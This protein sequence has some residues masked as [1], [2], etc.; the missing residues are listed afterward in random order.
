MD[1]RFLLPD[2][3]I[4]YSQAIWL[5]IGKKMEEDKKI[6]VYGLGVD[7]PKAMYQTLSEFPSIFGSDRCFDTPLS[8]DSLTGFGIGLAIS[9]FKPIHVHQRTDFLLLC[10]NQLINMAAKIKYISNGQ[11]SCPF[12]VRAITG[13]SWGQGGQHS[14]SFHSL[15]SNIPGLK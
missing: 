10:C 9:G 2:A 6:I 1:K 11:L 5:A 15:F 13:R 7:D 8:E 14:Q 3:P 12:V 4:S